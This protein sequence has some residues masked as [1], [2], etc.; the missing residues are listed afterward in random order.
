MGGSCTK[1]ND[2]LVMTPQNQLELAI[3]SEFTPFLRLDHP[4]NVNHKYST[5]CAYLKN[6]FLG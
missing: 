2:A 6:E 3:N 5:F 4:F 1:P